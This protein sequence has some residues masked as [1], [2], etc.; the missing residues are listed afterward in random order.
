MSALVPATDLLA[1]DLTGVVVVDVQWSLTTAGGPSARERYAAAHLPGAH[2][3]DL[4]AE[5]SGPP[6]PGGR[7]PMPTAHSVQEALRR[8]GA[9][10]GAQVVVYDQGP[11]MAA[12][13]AW[14]VLR[15][16]GVTDVRVLDGGLAAWVAAGGRTTTEVPAPGAGT[17]EVHAG[18][19]PV[20]DAES[21]AGLARDGVLVD[22][23]APE[24]YRGETEPIDPVAGHVP[25]ALN[26]PLSA[27]T[28]PDGRLRPT[29]DLR[30]LFE[31]HGIGPERPV[32]AYCGSGVT[33]ALGVL[34]LRE[35]GVEAALY[36]GSW[37]DWIGDPTRPVATG[38]EP[39]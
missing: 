12:A 39:G 1:D 5:L 15:Y 13:R 14:W 36:V 8:C 32:G 29:E 35:A 33:A 22:V 9:D 19:L 24:R 6:G 27:M 17:I 25:G 28:R 37:S 21:A 26:L 30:T 7:H 4:D 18:A 10:Q 2:H 23:R 20:L 16:F 34:A 11:S 31:E 38:A 3:V